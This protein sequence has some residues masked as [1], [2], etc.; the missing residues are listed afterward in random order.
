MLG[1]LIKYDL[2]SM[3]KTIVPLWITVIVLSGIFAIKYWGGATNTMDMGNNTFDLVL[4]IVLFSVAVAIVVMNILFVVQRFWNG[5]LKEEGYLMFTLPVTT[6]SLIMSKALSALII[7]LEVCWWQ[8]CLYRYSA[9]PLFRERSMWM[10][11]LLCGW[12]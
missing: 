10:R 1:K 8:C 9:L 4:F 2:K 6:R 7:S 3:L 11:F 12:N 5:L